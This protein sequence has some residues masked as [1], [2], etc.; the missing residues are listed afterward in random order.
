MTT[1]ATAHTMNADQFSRMALAALEGVN[2]RDN[3]DALTNVRV[4]GVGDDLI[5]ESTDGYILMRTRVAVEN[6]TTPAAPVLIKGTDLKAAA[7]ALK[8]LRLGKDA[9]ITLHLDGTDWH[10]GNSHWK[11]GGPLDTESRFP[12]LGQLFAKEQPEESAQTFALGADF[13]G[14]LSRLGKVAGGNPPIVVNP[15]TD[16]R[17]PVR[18]TV[19]DSIAGLLMPVRLTA[20]EDTA[21][22]APFPSWVTDAA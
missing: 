7:K 1:T 5:F 9:T 16:P 15:H 14:R 4:M 22:R 2:P 8:S 13:L 6:G 11:H 3:R 19:G 12:L 20:D 21:A 17:K 18:F 10:I